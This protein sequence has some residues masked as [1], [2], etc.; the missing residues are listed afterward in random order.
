MTLKS[1]TVDYNAAMRL[2]QF[3][4]LRARGALCS[5]VTDQLSTE[6]ASAFLDCFENRGEY[7]ADAIT[8][9]A[10]IATL[11]EPC[12]AEPGQRAT[13]PLLVERLS[14][15]FDPRYCLLY[16]RAFAQMITFC[17]K[18]PA[19]AKLDAALRRFGLESEGDLLE[20]KARL[21]K[22]PRMLDARERQRVRKVLVLSRVTLGA[23]VA[24]TSIALQKAKRSFPAAE[25]VLLGSPKL[26]QLFGGDRSLRIREIRYQAEG[27]LLDRLA[28]SLP[29]TAALEEE[30]ANLHPE[31]LIVIDPDSRLLQLGL[32]PALR[33]ESRYFF[34]ES[35]CFGEPG[36]G[37]M[38]QITLRWLNG[39]F[40]GQ[41]GI[42]AEILPAVSLRYEDKAFG[43]ELCHKL[44]QG[45]SGFL[46]AA[47]FGVG[48]NQQKRLPDPF[49]EDLLLRLLEDGSTVL[50]DKG[51]GEEELGRANR[52]IGGVKSSG[53]TVLEM[54]SESANQWLGAPQ[55]DPRRASAPGPAPVR[56]GTGPWEKALAMA[57]HCQML[58]WQGEIGAFSALVGE[59]DAYIGYDS[60]GQHIAAAL[61]VPTI[62]IFAEA[63]SPLFQERWRPS[64]PGIVKVVA[65]AS[66]VGKPHEPTR[67]LSE[68]QALLK[69]IKSAAQNPGRK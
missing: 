19:A 17:R 49:E 41:D 22:R 13:F 60:A 5:A 8:M 59:S 11:E 40:G 9:L 1:G 16:D 65:E 7:L 53:R 6:A 2:A 34:L 47:S 58:T 10:E 18:L 67:V 21:T 36:Q 28:S 27:G 44:R 37:S 46:V 54:D 62:D 14:D 63:A 64:G 55:K 12:L 29:V 24:I 50:L 45:G 39:I 26:H 61:G 51:F 69:E 56:A 15:S 32:L 20:R 43:R 30:T 48:G 33:D 38:S 35:R 23:D 66:S 57:T 68:I 31:E 4:E 25:L 3:R 52:L 42:N